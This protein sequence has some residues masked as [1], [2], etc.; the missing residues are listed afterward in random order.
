MK[1]TATEIREKSFEKNFR[2]YDKDEV[3]EFLK[4]LAEA[5]DK[6]EN[7]K[8]DLEKRLQFAEQEAKKLKDVEIS[9]FRTL[10]T[11]EDTG[12]SII[13]EANRT[14]HELLTEAHQS[15]DNMVREAKIQAQRILEEAEKKSADTL[16]ELKNRIKGFIR[17]YDALLNN[18]VLILKNLKRISADLEETLSKSD[19]DFEKSNIESFS[20][21][22][23]KLNEIKSNVVPSI[24][25][26]KE[27]TIVYQESEKIESPTGTTEGQESRDDAKETPTLE[28]T[29]EIPTSVERPF[30]EVKAEVPAETV[31]EL[32]STPSISD[33]NTKG[34]TQVK[35]QTTETDQK[36]DKKEGSF[37]DQLD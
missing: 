14:A 28:E 16:N 37:F 12:A 1:F 18:R 15:S 35:S 19:K 32:E 31:Q 27:R 7:E 13:E 24:S 23:D 29:V 3:T 4:T 2:G 21:L 22:L 11:A 6:L 20:D 30:E 34:T 26:E 33:E 10:K 8:I 5:W 9:L 17:D 25:E 36:K